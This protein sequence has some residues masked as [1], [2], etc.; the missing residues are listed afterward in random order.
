MTALQYI[1]HVI[2]PFACIGGFVAVIAGWA[3]GIGA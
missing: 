3:I 1:L 2:L